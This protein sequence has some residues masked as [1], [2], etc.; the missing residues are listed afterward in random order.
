M[1]KCTLL[2]RITKEGAIVARI[3]NKLLFFTTSPRTPAKMIPEIKLLHEAYSG[4][5]W[6]NTTQEQFIDELAQSDFFE[7]KGSPTDKAFSARDRINRA[8]KALGF[9]DLKPYIHLTE[10]GNAF[11]YGNRPQEIFLRQLLKFQLPSPYHTENKKITGVFYIRPYLE[12][13]RLVR[14]LEYITFDEFK[15]FAVQ[16]TDYHK[17]EIVRN[18]I[19]R[20]REEKAKNKGQYKRFVN[21]VWEDAILKIHSDRIAAGKTKTRETNDTSLKRFITTQKRNM[22]DYADACFRYMRYTGLISISHR[23]RSIS[24]FADKIVEVDFV[25][26]TV[27]RDPVFIDDEAAYKAHLFSANT[28]A[29]Y[30]DNRDNVVDVLMRIGSFTKRELSNKTLEELKD[31]RDEIIQKHKDTVIHKQI[32]EIKSYALYSEIIDTFNEIISAGYYDAPLMFEYNTWRAMTML[33]GGSIKGNFNFDDA[34]QP[35]STAAGNMPDIEC[36]YDDFSLS[37][38]VTLQAGQRQYE[39]EGEPVARHYGQLK[40]R[41]G[42]DTYCLFIAPTINPATLAH[43]YG[44]NHLSIALYGGKSKIIPLELDQFMQLIENSYTYETRPV[45]SDIRRFLDH[46]IKLCEN[47]TDENDWRCGIQACVDKWLSFTNK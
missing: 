13:L 29:L 40:K 4:Q 6:N 15:I 33:N 45:P 3:D 2:L 8:P 26:S 11:I 35:L 19:L 5:P 20:F 7:G 17:F 39:S 16:M 42:K 36:H 21:K 24:I 14:E 37:V 38:E 27:S 47:A 30:T 44:L 32:A 31:L 43:F 25:L 1:I 34:G 46:T 28:P 41:T 9:V 23:S 10:A 22:R 18:A 12:I